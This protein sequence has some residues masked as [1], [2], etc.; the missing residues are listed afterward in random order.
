MSIVRTPQ[1]VE[2]LRLRLEQSGIGRTNPRAHSAVRDFEEGLDLE[3]S[4][5][6]AVRHEAASR[7]MWISSALDPW[8]KR[9]GLTRAQA[10]SVAFDDS[11]FN[12]ANPQRDQVTQENL[13]HVHVQGDLGFGR[14]HVWLCRRAGEVHRQPLKALAAGRPRS[15]YSE[16]RLNATRLKTATR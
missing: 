9:H 5:A 13:R 8:A 6:R 4:A 10:L 16:V 3:E 7:E 15:A 2:Q 1:E 12:P 11:A 14:R